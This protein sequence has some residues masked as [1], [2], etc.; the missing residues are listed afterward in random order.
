MLTR[1]A[2][3]QRGN[4]E[5]ADRW[6]QRQMGKR[7]LAEAHKNH[8]VSD[9]AVLET[10]LCRPGTGRPVCG[11]SHKSDCMAYGLPLANRGMSELE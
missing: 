11:R 10:A 8:W 9:I 3:P 4:R 1:S 2:G 6:R 7:E 5:G